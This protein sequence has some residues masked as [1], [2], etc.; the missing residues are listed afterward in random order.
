MPGYRSRQ[1]LSEATA[2]PET[3]QQPAHTCRA[4]PVGSRNDTASGYPPSRAPGHRPIRPAPLS[5]SGH[6]LTHRRT[7]SS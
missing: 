2:A 1:S 7:A 5:T 3:D 6:S 4:T